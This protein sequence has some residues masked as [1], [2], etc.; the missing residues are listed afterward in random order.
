MY[1]QNYFYQLVKCLLYNSVE[2]EEVFIE[3][4]KKFGKDCYYYQRH[5]FFDDINQ[6]VGYNIVTDMVEYICRTTEIDFD[7]N[8]DQIIPT[9]FYTTGYIPCGYLGPP[10]E[11][12][13]IIAQSHK[14]C[15]RVLRGL[16][17]MLFTKRY[18]LTKE[19]RWY[20]K[21]KIWTQRLYEFNNNKKII[22]NHIYWFYNM[23]LFFD[24]KT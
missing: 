21:R 23:I 6:D 5:R 24:S 22:P 19:D 1:P 14:E 15:K 18:K 17:W 9:H 7:Y 11:C 10:F 4:E 16:Y 20:I 8:K 13:Y 12:E 3:Y 2:F